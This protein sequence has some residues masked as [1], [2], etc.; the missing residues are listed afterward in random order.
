MCVP[1]SGFGNVTAV[2][3]SPGASVVSTFGVSP[4]SR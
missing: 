2:I 1:P 4:G 3:N